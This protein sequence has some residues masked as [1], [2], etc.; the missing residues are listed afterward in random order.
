VDPVYNQGK[1]TARRNSKNR[2]WY[3]FENLLSEYYRI[4]VKWR[5]KKNM[6]VCGEQ[7]SQR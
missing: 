4:T 2:L 1:L 3:E 5:C 7:N 6:I